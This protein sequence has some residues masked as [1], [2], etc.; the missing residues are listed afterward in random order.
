M[1]SFRT[2]PLPGFGTPRS[3]LITGAVGGLGLIAALILMEWGG[4]LDRIL[5]MLFLSS[6]FP[7]NRK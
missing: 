1:K 6:T 7:R 4:G 3:Y 2:Q 5:A